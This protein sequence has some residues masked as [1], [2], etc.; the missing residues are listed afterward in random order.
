RR[1]V[2]PAPRRE[3]RPCR[4]DGTAI[5]EG[6]VGRVEIAQAKPGVVGGDHGVR[7]G[8]P[9]VVEPDVAR[10]RPPKHVFPTPELNDPA[11]SRATHDVQLDKRARAQRHTTWWLGREAGRDGSQESASKESSFADD[12][13]VG[14]HVTIHTE[15]VARVG[16]EGGEVR[17]NLAERD[18][19]L[20]LAGH[21][22]RVDEDV[23]D[24]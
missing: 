22:S 16:K 19:A 8:D 21:S 24:L 1:H 4:G 5:H 7:A 20:G 13:V 11:R 9:E 17:L 15:A 23:A 18:G 14:D 10:G 3:L 2:D 6:R 12:V